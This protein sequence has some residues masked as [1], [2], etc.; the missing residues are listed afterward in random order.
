MSR[1]VFAFESD[2]DGAA[3]LAGALGLPC[4]PITLHRFPDL[5]SLVRVEIAVSQPI[6]Y[7][8]LDRPNGKLF[9]L[10]L[11]ADSFAGLGSTPPILVV[12]Y[13]PYMRQD[14]AFHRGEAVS[15][16]VMGRTLD[17][18]FS[19]IVTVDPH[20][21]RTPSLDRLFT[22]AKTVCL[23]ASSILA[24][25]ILPELADALLVGPDVESGPLVR[26]V[27]AETGCDWMCMSKVRSADRSVSISQEGTTESV[28]GRRAILIDDVCSS[29]TTLIEASRLLHEAGATSVEALVV[30]ALHDADAIAALEKA[31]IHR[32]R[33]TDSI[34]HPS[35]SAT[36]APLLAG[37]VKDLGP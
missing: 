32:L 19:A 29:G 11:A 28:S 27:A 31:G 9:D 25:M 34:L 14:V 35:N 17:G 7:R 22:S 23:S 37:A 1:A 30:H 16:R 10:L 3:T 4:H 33:S 36:L 13:L 2:L 5:E 15:Q 18:V 6:L 20:L 26:A 24:R 21:H 8:R 12:P